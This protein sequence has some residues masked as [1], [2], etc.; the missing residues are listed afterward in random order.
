MWMVTARVV[1]AMAASLR[2]RE[3]VLAAR[4][5]GV[6]PM[7]I[8]IRHIA[9]NLASFLVV[10]ATLNVNT[11]I[12]GETSLSYLGLGVRPPDVSLGTLIADGAPSVTT[13]PWLF[14][15]PVTA[16]IVITLTVNLIGDALRDALTREERSA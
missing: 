7:P 15:P 16:L 8:I 6:R 14:A 12:I 1:R 13:F 2:E 11:A 10:D 9:P 5:L 4:Y 3:Y